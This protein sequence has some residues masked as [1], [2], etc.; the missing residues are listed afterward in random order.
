MGFAQAV[1]TCFAQYASFTGRARRSEYW[2]WIL[3]QALVWAFAGAVDMLAFPSTLIGGPNG[4]GPVTALVGLAMLLPTLAVTAR[5]LHDIDKSGWWQLLGFVPI[6][7]GLIMLFWCIRDS[8]PGDNRFGADPTGHD[9]TGA[10]GP[11]IPGLSG[12]AGRLGDDPADLPARGRRDPDG[13]GEPQDLLPFPREGREGQAP[14]R[15]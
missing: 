1:A 8:R 4:I 2:W 9:G 13:H 7:G 5:R 14:P 3:F 12:L 11:G 10:R 15:S 6:V